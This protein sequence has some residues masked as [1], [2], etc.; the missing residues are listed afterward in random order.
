MSVRIDEG[1]QDF[2]QAK[3]KKR[4]DAV[5]GELAHRIRAS[6]RVSLERFLAQMSFKY[7]IRRVIV[8][9][10]ITIYEVLGFYYIQ[11]GYILR[12]KHRRGQRTGLSLAK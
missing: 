4:L 12:R 9:E 3:M 8:R 10:Y 11:D 6:K 2:N 5:E 7:G 1:L